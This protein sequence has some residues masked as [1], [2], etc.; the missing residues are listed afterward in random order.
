MSP[1]LERAAIDLIRF[2]TAPTAQIKLANAQ[3]SLPSRVEALAG[4][5]YGIPAFRAAVEESV[6]KG[7]SYPPV[8][9]GQDHE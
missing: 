2:L 9:Y 3:P 6:R 5:T 4:I 8:G 1:A 7:Q